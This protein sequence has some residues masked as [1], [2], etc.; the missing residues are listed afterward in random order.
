MEVRIMSKL[1]ELYEKIIENYKNKN[2]KKEIL[3]SDTMGKFFKTKVSDNIKKED[4]Q[5]EAEHYILYLWKIK[6]NKLIDEFSH[7]YIISDLKDIAFLKHINFEAILQFI[8]PQTEKVKL[9]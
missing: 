7:V 1:D 6:H 3:I 2:Y 5:T 9:K 8:S 4:F